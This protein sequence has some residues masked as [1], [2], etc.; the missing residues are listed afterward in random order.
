MTDKYFVANL[1]GIEG[2][3]ITW[4]GV[5]IGCGLLLGVLLAC[6]EESVRT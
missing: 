1:L 5:I 3:N 2:L 4:Y 6:W